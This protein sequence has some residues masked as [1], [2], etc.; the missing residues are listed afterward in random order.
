M[1]DVQMP[2]GN[3]FLIFVHTSVIILIYKALESRFYASRLPPVSHFFTCV[4]RRR[5]YN[6]KVLNYFTFSQKQSIFFNTFF[7][8]VFRV[9]SLSVCQHQ[10]CLKESLKLFVLIDDLHVLLSQIHNAECT[11][12]LEL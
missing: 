7:L 6:P 8:T 10:N 5:C 11:N 1:Y 4:E 2:I 9:K 12:T 3:P